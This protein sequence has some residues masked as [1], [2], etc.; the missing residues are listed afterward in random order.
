MNKGER[1]RE[2]ILNRGMLHSSQYG[3]ADITIGTISK[4]SGLSRTGVISHFND[5][6]DMQVAILEYS[7]RQFVE[8]VI[9]PSKHEDAFIRLKNMLYLWVDWTER[10]FPGEMTSCPFIK[11]IVEYEHREDSIVRQYAFTEQTQLLSFMT[12]LVDKAKKQKRIHASEISHEIAFELYSLYVGVTV[13]SSL[14]PSADRYARLRSVI[15]RGIQRYEI[16]S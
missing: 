2:L 9:K 10:L 3:L 8:N 13:V 14:D 15:D 16:S 7:G 6:D 12:H 5:K 4:L 1:T 11:A